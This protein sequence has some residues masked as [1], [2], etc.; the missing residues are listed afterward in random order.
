MGDQN[1]QIVSNCLNSLHYNREYITYFL[2]QT[3]IF[4]IATQNDL[5]GKFGSAVASRRRA[6][7]EAND[8]AVSGTLVIQLSVSR[9]EFVALD[10]LE[11]NETEYTTHL[12]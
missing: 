11:A 9:G 6:V 3:C 4:C 12:E 1:P 10:V 8:R 5:C 2:I 7:I